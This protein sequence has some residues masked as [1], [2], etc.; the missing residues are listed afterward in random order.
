MLVRRESGK[1]SSEIFVRRQFSVTSESAR[2]L[3]G[4][5]S[6]FGLGPAKQTSEGRW[7]NRVCAGKGW[8]SGS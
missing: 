5:T 6:A 4:Q 7:K 2:T 8:L 3:H 1:R